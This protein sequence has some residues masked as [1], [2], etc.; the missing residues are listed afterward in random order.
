MPE[1]EL[2]GWGEEDRRAVIEQLCHGAVAYKEIKEREL[3]PVVRDWL[4]GPQHAALD[5]Y[6]PERVTLGNGQ[7]AKVTYEAG[8]EPWIALRVQQL[9]GVRETPAVAAGRVPLVVQVL[10]PNQ[11][12]W[13]VTKDLCSFWATGYPQ[14]RKDLAG[15]YPRHRWPDDPHAPTEARETSKRKEQG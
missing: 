4:S 8:R 10:A 11:R 2:P 5:T 12:P 1:L 13:Q 3:W 7:A 6:A 15:R 9:F 14:M